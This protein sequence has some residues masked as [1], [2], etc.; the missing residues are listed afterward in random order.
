MTLVLALDVGTSSVRARVYDERGGHVEGVEA[1]TRYEVTHG[2]DGRAEFDPDHLVEAT[3]AALADALAAAGGPVAAVGTSCFWHSLV[4]VD[5][6]GRA[7]GPLL[8]WRDLRSASAAEALARA[9]DA[10]A[11]HARTGCVLHPS[12]WPA[13]LA[14]LAREEPETFRTAAR[15]LSFSDYLYGQLTGDARTSLSMAS[16]T[17]LLDISGASWDEELLDTLGLAPERLPEITDEPAGETTPWFP[18]LGD[19]ACSNAGAGCLTA[20]RAALMIGTS[21]AYR[22]VREARDAQPRPGLFLYSLDAERVVE[23]GALSDGGNLYAWLEQTLKL[24]AA[25]DLDAA[26]PDAHGL[27]FL[28]LLG[29]ERS[30]GWHPRARGAIAGLTFDTTPEDLLQA[31]LEGV[32]YRFAALAE[33][34]PEVREVVATGHALFVDHAWV[35]I[36]ADVLERPIVLSEVDEASARGAAA[37]VLERL[38]LEADPAPTGEVFQPRTERFEAYRS[39]RERQQDL[40]RSVT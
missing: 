18:A 28:T 14:W 8:T 19:G 24:R 40:Y 3:R 21:G 27:T 32:T 15:F 1:Q 5:R 25:P 34:L 12:Y 9:L 37:L 11:V 6:R 22:V 7:I 16:G 33:R 10:E 23:G 4:P 29:G 26:E 30:P 31:G 20:D 2:H 35:Q 17:G 39:A 36:L 13:K 38:G